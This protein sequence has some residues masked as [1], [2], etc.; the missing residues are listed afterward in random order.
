M[1]VRNDDQI[2]GLCRLLSLGVRLLTLIEMVTRRQLSQQSATLTGLYEGNPKRETN[3]PT[4]VRL[5]RAFRGIH[6][7]CLGP[8]HKP[9][10][11][12]T[13]LNDIQRHLLQM[14]GLP[15]ALYQPPKAAPS[16]WDRLARRGAQLW[17]QFCHTLN[18]GCCRP[19]SSGRSSTRS[20]ATLAGGCGC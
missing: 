3:Q 14:L 13:P 1:Y 18:Q 15:E 12:T 2:K 11:V 16:L 4:A 7:V 6:R 5:L 9:K 19:M 20:T 8:A 17:N 10:W